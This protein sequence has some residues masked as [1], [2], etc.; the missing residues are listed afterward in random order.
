[1][2]TNS[3]KE[4]DA[5]RQAEAMM[6]LYSDVNFTAVPFKGQWQKIEPAG[7]DRKVNFLLLIPAGV[8]TVETEK[9]NHLSIDFRIF[10]QDASGK[11]AGNIGQRLD[12]KLTAQEL[13]Q[14]Q[15]RGISYTNVLTLAPGQYVVHFIVRDNLKGALG[16]VVAPLKVD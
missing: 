10:A 1:W 12:L 5:A 3:G 8:A 7:S 15:T 2:F 4:T 14:I 13:S 9:E 6:A 16:S 11:V